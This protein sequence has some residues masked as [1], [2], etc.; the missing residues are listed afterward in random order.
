M[1]F[2]YDCIGTQPTFPPSSLEHDDITKDC[3]GMHGSI[4]VL[5]DK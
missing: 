4:D 2:G 3:I 5:D 1:Y